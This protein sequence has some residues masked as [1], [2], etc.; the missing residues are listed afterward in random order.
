MIPYFNFVNRAVIDEMI[1]FRTGET[2]LGERVALPI[3]DILQE[4]LKATNA[5]F[6]LLGI[7]EDIGVRANGGVGGAHTAWQPALR[8]ILNI[9][10]TVS[11]PG[12]NILLLGSFDF[13]EWMSIAAD[14]IDQ[15]ELRKIVVKIDEVVFP[16]IEAIIEAGKIPIVIGGGHNNAYPLLK[17]ASNAK[18]QP[19]NCINLDA[20]SDYRMLEGRHSGNGFR[21]AKEEGFLGKYSIVGL[22]RN[23]NSQSV[24]EA[25]AKD[26]DVHAS[27]YEDIFLEEAQTFP[28]AVTEAIGHTAGKPCGIELDLDCIAQVLSSAATPCGIT[29][30]QARIYLQLCAT[31]TDVAYL[32]VTEGAVKLRDG[33]VDNSTAKLIAYLVADFMRVMAKPKNK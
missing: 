7:P 21:Y 30:L 5:R 9:Q 16:V 22:H 33:R 27:F 15:T 29:S 20:H 6:V 1:A 4:N 31:N 25:I 26:Q 23:Y 8:A 32:H 24:I 10:N 28:A 12:E 13:R 11:L 18:G 14:T 3:T 19:V 2:K 17:G